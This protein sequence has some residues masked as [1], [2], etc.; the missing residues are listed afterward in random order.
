[1]KKVVVVSLLLHS[2]C[3]FLYYI[4]HL[5]EC[6]AFLHDLCYFFYMNKFQE[7]FIELRKSN[8]WKQREVADKLG[9]TISS[10]SNY[11]QGIREPSLDILMSICQL[12]DVSADYLIGLTDLY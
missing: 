6:Q 9:L 7:R 5:V 12:F 1:M 8:G 10:I 2:S 3:I 4:T 11:E